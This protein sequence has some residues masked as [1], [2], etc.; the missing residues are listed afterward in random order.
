MDTSLFINSGKIMLKEK[1]SYYAQ[2]QGQMALG[3]RPWCDFIIYT[4]TDISIQRINLNERY[5][6]ENLTKLLSFYDNC[7]A[8]EIVSPCHTV[9]LPVRKL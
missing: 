5:W 7:I 4:Q 8:P 9:G 2:I 6:Q 1:H 3:E